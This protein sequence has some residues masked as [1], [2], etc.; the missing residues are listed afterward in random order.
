MRPLVLSL[1]F[2]ALAA[3]MQRAPARAQQ[4]SMEAPDPTRLDVERLPPEAIAVKRDMFAHGLFVQGHAG[5]LGFAGGLGRLS[6]PGMFARVGLG[7]ELTD[8]LLLGAAVELS[9]HET[10]APPPPG[11]AGF[12]LIDSL[13]EV[14]FQIPVSARA[15]PW[16]AAEGGVDWISGNLLAAYG[17][18][19]ASQVGINY[20]GSIGFDWHM[21]N[22]HY[23]I[24]LLAGARLY[25][26]LDGPNGDKTIGIH[27]ALYLKY[28]F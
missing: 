21:L 13:F 23:S 20:G 11:P 6:L 4:A 2:V 18:R 5:G 9:L 28:V 19:R 24:G 26:N 25:P 15:T 16:V 7:Y 8:W 22:R 27:S 3:S 12:Q 14:R 1:L 10:S 17:V